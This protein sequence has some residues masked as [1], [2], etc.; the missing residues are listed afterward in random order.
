MATSKSR[1]VRTLREKTSSDEKGNGKTID[2]LEKRLNQIRIYIL[3]NKKHAKL[4]H[5]EPTLVFDKFLYLGGL[6]S[7]NDKVCF[8][9][10][11]LYSNCYIF[12]FSE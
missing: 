6:K 12:L 3:N 4:T 1:L 11:S 2:P 5:A 8:I 10:F 7:L 9:Q